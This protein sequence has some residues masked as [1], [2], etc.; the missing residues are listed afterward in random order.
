MNYLNEM[1]AI[2]QEIH[3]IDDKIYELLNSKKPEHV[4]YNQW[5]AI[6]KQRAELYDYLLVAEKLHERYEGTRV[7]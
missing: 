6:A 5:L 3:Q 4:I 7:N 2:R 1:K